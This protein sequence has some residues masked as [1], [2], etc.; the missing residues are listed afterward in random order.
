MDHGAK[1]NMH[2]VGRM[3]LV[4]GA[5]GWQE[6]V[7]SYP[8]MIPDPLH[9]RPQALQHHALLRPLTIVYPIGPFHSHCMISGS[10]ER[11]HIRQHC[12]VGC[13][14]GRR[15]LLGSPHVARDWRRS[16]A[17]L[18]SCS[19]MTSCKADF[20]ILFFC[21]LLRSHSFLSGM[22]NYLACIS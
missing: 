5:D 22:A 7:V 14:D 13:F 17:E 16:P 20:G 6:H 8:L 11:I 18:R 9:R 19:Y 10:P 12:T 2:R 21:G 15:S 3:A 4:Y 1:L